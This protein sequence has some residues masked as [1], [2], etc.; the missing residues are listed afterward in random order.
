MQVTVEYSPRGWPIPTGH[1]TVTTLRSQFTYGESLK[2]VFSLK[3]KQTMESYLAFTREI[4]RSF[5]QRTLAIEWPSLLISQEF[6]LHLMI[7]ESCSNKRWWAGWMPTQHANSAFQNLTRAA[8]KFTHF[9]SVNCV[10]PT[11]ISAS[12][13]GLLKWPLTNKEFLLNI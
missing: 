11:Q 9:H 13:L 5:R 12:L 7:S 3:P 6:L 2:V 1:S 8:L 10:C 4:P